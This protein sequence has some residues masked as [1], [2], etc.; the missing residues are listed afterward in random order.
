VDDKKFVDDDHNEE[1]AE[2]PTKDNTRPWAEVMILIILCQIA[3]M[4]FFA[5]PILK[6][7]ER[8]CAGIDRISPP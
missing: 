5:L 2:P 1:K 4:F 7:L 6:L 8:L 3:W